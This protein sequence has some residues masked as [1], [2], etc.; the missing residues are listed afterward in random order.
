MPSVT[1]LVSATPYSLLLAGWQPNAWRSWQQKQIFMPRSVYRLH[2]LPDSSLPETKVGRVLVQWE[3]GI[4]PLSYKFMWSSDNSFRL[5]LKL[6][7]ENNLAL[8][9]GPTLS[10]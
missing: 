8:F 6:R 5:S 10:C 4:G 1:L 2:F 9:L 7:E 3:K